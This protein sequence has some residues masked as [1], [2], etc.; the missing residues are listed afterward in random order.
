MNPQLHFRSLLSVLFLIHLSVMVYSQDV[1]NPWTDI[2]I[3]QVRGKCYMQSLPT[4]YRLLS[5]NL[6]SMKTAL[7][8]S[9]LDSDP[10]AF[11]RG[12]VIEL[13]MPD[14]K[15]AHFRVARTEVLPDNSVPS[16]PQIKTFI[17]KG[18]EDP[19]AIARIDY[20]LFGFHAMIMSPTGWI[21][22]D[23]YSLSNTQNYICYDRRYTTDH[24]DFICETEGSD[25][26]R[27]QISPVRTNSL[28]R[29]AGTQLKTYRLAVACT[30]EYAAT[31][32][33]TVPGAVSGIVTSVNR[34][35]G[36]YELELSVRLTLIANNTVLVYT[37]SLTDPYT[38]GN[39]STML[40]QN[41][42]TIT[43][44]IG[45]ANYDIGHVFS[46]G[47]GGVAGL[48]VV[49]NT[50]NKS[51]GVTGR[52]APIGD[53]YDIDYVAHEM[54]H[55]FGG[56]HTFNSVTGSCS[57]NRS[58][59]AA[60]EPGSGTTIMAYAGI[61]G[62][63]DIQPH[64]DAIF[65]VKSFDEIQTFITSG[66]GS[67]CPVVTATGNTAPVITVPANKSIPYLTPFTLTGS[68]TDANGDPLTYLWEEYDTTSAGSAPPSPPA[69]SNSPIFRVFTP[70]TSPSRTFPQISD[71]VNNVSTL[72]E[73]LP[74]YGRQLKFRLSVRDNRLNGG[75]VT[76][77]DTPVQLNVVNTGAAFAVT[78]PN[79]AVTWISGTTQTV[80]WNVSGTTAAP[81]SC[82]NVNI[83]LSNDGGYTYPTVLAS[84]VPNSGSAN[85][86]VPL[87][88]T[89]Q[90][91][92]KVEASGNYF[93]DI[94]NTNFTISG[95]SAVLTTLATNPLSATTYCA[96]ASVNVDFAGDGPANAGNIYTAQL[97]NASGN[98][99]AP[100]AIG[101][102]TST[103][104]FGT[105][106]CV[107]PVGT[108]QGT[109]YR[110]RVISSNP[111]I[112]GTDNLSNL[113][114]L[115][116]V[117]SIG[118]VSG[119][120]SVC[121]G[122]SGVV[123]SIA[124]VANATTYAWT[125]PSGASITAGSGTNSITVSFSASAASG[126]I[127]VTPS[128]SC[129]T[130]GSSPA[131]AVTVNTLPSAAGAITGPIQVCMGSSATFSVGAISGSTSYSWTLPTGASITSGSG[132][133]SITVSFGTSAVSGSVSVSGTNSCGN[134]TGSSVALNVVSIPTAPA[135]SAGGSTTFCSGGSVNLS[136][137][138]PANTVYQWRKDGVLISGA[139]ASTY[140]AN[141]TGNYDAVFY[142]N[143]VFS[144]SQVYSI[145]DA[146][147]TGVSSPITVSGYTGTVASGSIRVTLN[148]THT[149]DADLIIV[150]VSPSGAILPLA[151]AVGSSGD[152][153]TNTVFTDAGATT[154]PATGAPYT[155][156]YKPW[157]SAVTTC[158][159]STINTFAALGGG[160]LNPNGTWNLK[161]IDN[162]AQDLGTINNWSILFPA[163]LNGPCYATSNSIPVTASLPPVITSLSPSSGASGQSVSIIGT[164]FTGATSV[165]FNS[166]AATFTVVNDQTIST[167]VPVGATT[168]FVTVTTPCGTATSPV[169]FSTSVAVSLKVLLEGY[170]LPS[171]LMS[172][173]L[174]G[175]ACDTITLEL[176]STIS[177]FATLYSVKSTISTSGVG[178]FAFPAAAAG[179]SYY[180]VVKH[181]N[182]VAT[183]SSGVVLLSG[184]GISFD[185]STSASQA[186]G[187]N[188]ISVGAG[189]FAIRAGDLN[190]D[191]F[192]N[193][194]DFTQLN[195]S[196]GFVSGYVTSD[197]TG[198]GYV[199]S[200]DYS[201]VETNAQLSISSMHP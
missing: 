15:S 133:N 93:F 64:S 47:G 14:G 132:T 6:A 117:G 68:A 197:L 113:T 42:T 101:T 78:A 120:A 126:T 3:N 2:T 92:V 76:N 33:G 134:G 186:F 13:P 184:S 118:A 187:S 104:S 85:V 91:R 106:S 200:A 114:I 26:H 116:N 169:V 164:D 146:I 174:A 44:L 112:T 89:T 79:T 138:P 81:I 195:S 108:A 28:S 18:I 194:T 145:P 181:R 199:E 96:G 23:P 73:I 140:T 119:T 61:C 48:G 90:A 4:Q 135:L 182:S 183:W 55:Q 57:G 141:A 154:I 52:N 121:Q 156:T 63:D 180:L 40:G 178:S 193:H 98:F 19:Y 67:T 161:V 125:L 45:S 160:A 188:Q 150:L 9:V 83:L 94:S 170:M 39:G 56:N 20:T 191:G 124:P 149:W 12:P 167:T 107:I 102:L 69:G 176:A 144:N 166:T 35:T 127:S 43:S 37:D 115:Q 60:Y 88:L 129:S 77:N 109:L 22:I 46:T 34:V 66:G 58:S 86:T 99:S 50:S 84:A 80:T 59:G 185:F 110:I 179:S 41:Q 122:Q 143:E 8:R 151:N 25:Y 173:A 17:A 171:G 87:V 70:Q 158:V 177:P 130:G 201:L 148:I 189:K 38:N 100:V 11:A 74:T 165:Q 49:C 190:Q 196:L 159:T 155:G 157:A 62:A 10:N 24:S 111:A 152:N 16:Y 1:I 153:F 136:F 163:S 162:G 36:V 95:G 123:Y 53:D 7:N 21:F 128:N 192:V 65:A 5:L 72:G 175:G 137:T 103:A 27:S 131:F 147:C 30:G 105:I 168:G 139:T 172:S 51:R 142:G 32:G 54:G 97:S 29:T 75:G 31:Y 71:I 82:A 198:D